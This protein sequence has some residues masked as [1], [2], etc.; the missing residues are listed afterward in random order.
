[1]KTLSSVQRVA[2]PVATI[3]TSMDTLMGPNVLEARKIITRKI[4]NTRQDPRH[5]ADLKRYSSK[6]SRCKPDERITMLKIDVVAL[7]PEVRSDSAGITS[8]LCCTAEPAGIA[9]VD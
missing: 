8:L 3:P 6:S 1:V 4:L 5:C 9:I 2:V 7:S